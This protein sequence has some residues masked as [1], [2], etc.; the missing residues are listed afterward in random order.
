MYVM[1][2]ILAALFAATLIF[3][4]VGATLFI[5]DTPTAEAKSY[6]SGKKGFSNNNNS[7]NIQK[8]DTTKDQNNATTNKNNST[9]TNK[10]DTTKKGGFFL[11][12]SDERI[13]AWRTC[14]IIIR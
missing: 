1:K 10:A 13:N 11:R 9:S 3:S 6:K 5:S 4:T 8:S 12:W 14:W 2:K 7:S